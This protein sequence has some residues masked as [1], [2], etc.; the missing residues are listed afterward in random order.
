MQKIYIAIIVLNLSTLGLT[1]AFA[2]DSVVIE[3]EATPTIEASSSNLDNEYTSVEIDDPEFDDSESINLSKSTLEVEPVVSTCIEKKAE[4][5]IPPSNEKPVVE[6]I[7]M[8]PSTVE[9]I[10]ENKNTIDIQPLPVE[11]TFEERLVDQRRQ[12]ERQ[13]MMRLTKQLEITRMRQEV[14][15]GKKME[16]AMRESIENI[17]IE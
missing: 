16:R 7:S 9:V 8:P 4:V 5:L 1:S 12:L 11:K 14:L 3:T 10:Q 15:L 6:K 2:L 13:N 17:K